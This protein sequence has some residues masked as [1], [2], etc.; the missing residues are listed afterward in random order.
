MFLSLQFFVVYRFLYD[1]ENRTALSYCNFLLLIFRNINFCKQK[2]PR[3]C[4]INHPIAAVCLHAHAIWN[5]NCQ[6]INWSSFP[7]VY[8]CVCVCVIERRGAHNK[9]IPP[10]FFTPPWSR[11]EP[12][13]PFVC[14][15]N[16][17]FSNI[18]IIWS[19][20]SLCLI[21]FTMGNAAANCMELGIK[22]TRRTKGGEFLRQEK[23]SIYININVCG[24]DAFNKI[25]SPFLVGPAARFVNVLDETP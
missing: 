25:N 16:T 2:T 24:D 6:F 7:L 22:H 12:S 19:V 9:T 21:R 3:Y 4:W 5:H 20:F 11:P 18:Q 13:R 10:L 1:I 17:S 15:K 8:K 14:V 23:V